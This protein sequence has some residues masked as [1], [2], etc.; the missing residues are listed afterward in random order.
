MQGIGLPQVLESIIAE[1]TIQAAQAPYEY[2]AAAPARSNVELGN[3]HHAST[4]DLGFGE[5]NVMA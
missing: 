3:S 4:H 1:T 2:N 5:N